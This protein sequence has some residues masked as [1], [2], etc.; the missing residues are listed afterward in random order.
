VIAL[1][2]LAARMQAPESPRWLAMKGRVDE[3]NAVLRKLS[4]EFGETRQFTATQGAA[5][6]AATIRVAP[7]RSNAAG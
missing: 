1:L 3:A 7:E 5:P 4:V 6:E 2:F